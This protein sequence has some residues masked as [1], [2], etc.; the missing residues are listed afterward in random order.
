MFFKYFY[1]FMFVSLHEAIGL[2]WCDV[3]WCV[4]VRGCV[5]VCVNKRDI[6]NEA[7][8]WEST[9][10]L[11]ICIKHSKEQNYSKGKN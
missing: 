4:C 10:S 8:D 5:R 7:K 1:I 3:M 6:G 11:F 9:P 2:M